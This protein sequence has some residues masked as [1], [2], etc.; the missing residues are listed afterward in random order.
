MKQL[1][2]L[3]LFMLGVGMAVMIF[4]PVNF[5]TVV[6]ISGVLILGYNLFCG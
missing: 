1:G 5:W 3:A 6:L 4:V 2:G